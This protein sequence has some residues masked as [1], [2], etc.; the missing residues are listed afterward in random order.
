MKLSVF[1]KKRRDTWDKLESLLLQVDKKGLKTLSP[2]QVQEL[3]RLYPTLAVDIAQARACQADQRTQQRLNQM[4]VRIHGILY[5]KKSRQPFKAMGRFYLKGYPK[6]FREMWPYVALSLVLFL[7]PCLGTFVM[8]Q[9]DPRTA[10]LFVPGGETMDL[11]DGRAGVSAEDISERFRNTPN[12]I[13][14]AGI[15]TN[16]ISVALNAFALGITAGIGTCFVM[17]LNAMMLGGIAGHF[18]NHDLI[19][20]FCSFI[21]PHGALEIFAIIL[22]GAAGLRLGLSLAIPGELTRKSSLQKG[23]KD[24]VLLV[25]GTIPMFILAGLIEGF[26]TPSY[27]SGQFK[28][29]IGIGALGITLAYLFL[30]GFSSKADVSL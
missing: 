22:A 29:L 23:A 17:I 12:S 5:R 3:T 7:L 25:L 11:V 13:M 1:I 21:V 18:A 8:V 4:A 26:I 30:V 14:A 16:N 15:T 20:A 27:M 10:Y 6:H 24:A 19:Y 28:I 9:L 2:D